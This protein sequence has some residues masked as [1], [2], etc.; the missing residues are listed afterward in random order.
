MEDIIKKADV[1]IEALP[2]IKKFQRKT[3]VI[4]Y[5]GSILGE[6]KIRKVVLQDIVFLNFVG[7]HI[8][9]VH[10]GGPNISER[11][12]LEGKKT[13]FVDGMR[14]TDEETL[15]VVEEELRRLNKLIVEE[16]IQLGAKAISLDGKSDE[17]IFVKKKKAKIDLGFVGQI[18]RID[19]QSILKN[20]YAGYITVII[21]MGK[22]E[23][24]KA[25][26]VNA[27]EAASYIASALLAEKLVLLTNVRGIMRNPEEFNSLLSTLSIDEAKELIKEK[28]IQEGM[29]PKVEACIGALQKGVK[30]T[31]IIDAR[32]PHSLL[33]EIFTDKG[34]GTEIVK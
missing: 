25:Y 32:L 12:R 20:L 31:H 10:G 17:I 22:G 27:D 26:N 33:I 4:K 1:L 2:Y 34:I 5:G 24:M 15:I 7:I 13:E 8:V 9:L 14:V 18:V 19:T 16:L 3:M 11:M 29:I 28:V 30:K 21:P 23:D 6:E